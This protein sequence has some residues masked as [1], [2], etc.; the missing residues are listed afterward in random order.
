V[1]F[2]QDTEA[3]QLTRPQSPEECGW[4]GQDAGT[5]ESPCGEASANFTSTDEKDPLEAKLSSPNIA[6]NAMSRYISRA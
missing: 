6:H 1:E 2:A 4:E 3:L 5:I